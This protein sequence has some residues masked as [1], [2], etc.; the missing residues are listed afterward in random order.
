[1]GSSCISTNHLEQVFE[2]PGQQP[3]CAIQGF[4]QKVGA[5][6]YIESAEL[7]DKLRTP[8]A[9]RYQLL[10]MPVTPAP[11]HDIAV[12]RRTTSNYESAIGLYI[13]DINTD[14]RALVYSF[15]GDAESRTIADFLLK[16]DLAENYV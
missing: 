14:N 12:Y 11:G 6:Y 15:I 7:V 16:N 9:D 10:P 2:I 8:M 3:R 13:I 5:A 4:P 1:M